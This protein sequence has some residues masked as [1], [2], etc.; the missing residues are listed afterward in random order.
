VSGRARDKRCDGTTSKR[1]FD[2]M[3][4]ELAT[5]PSLESLLDRLKAVAYKAVEDRDF[6]NA[7]AAF[8]KIVELVPTDVNARFVYAQLID[9]GSHKKRAEARDLMLSI[10]DEHPEVFDT[11]TDGNLN[12]I[13]KTAIRCKDVGPVSKAIELFRKLSQAS[14]QAADYFVLSEVLTNG[15]FLEESISSLEKAITLDPA[16]DTPMNRETLEIGKSRLSQPT[17][18]A[19]VPKKKIGRYPE[20]KDFLGD[21]QGLIKNHIAV[22]LNRE[23]K[24]IS[25]STRFF[26]MG[27]CFARNL[28]RSLHQSGYVAQHMEISEYINTTFAN[29]VFVD[30]LSGAEID[31][32]IRDRIAELLPPSWSKE[33]TLQIIKDSSVFI[34]TLGVAPAFFDRATGD[35][36]LPRPSALNSRVLAE[37]YRYRTTSVQENVDNVLYLINFVRSI[38]PKI[39]IV[40]TVS[41]VPLV[42]SFEYES[43]VQADCLSKST[44]RLVAHEVVHNS[45]VS[46][47]VYWPS[48]EVFR[49]AGSN[50]S[51]FYA[52]DDGA[53]WHVSEEKV[54]GTIKAFVDMFSET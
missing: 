54:G 30:W 51:N 14:N 26:T 38:S 2:N 10:L 48:F 43:A 9:D 4:A 42:A 24:F 28:A 49:W 37:K 17:A 35:F 20:T 52:A 23:P 53:A 7:L 5:P 16:F 13:R 6:G 22:D 31:A 19:A 33:N 25:K 29:R 3:T 39:K 21:I 12:L 36:V 32:A 34:L 8:K 18:K 40:V 15:D 11:P 1:R 41:P 46:D 50:A 45:D 47:I 27:S 44:M